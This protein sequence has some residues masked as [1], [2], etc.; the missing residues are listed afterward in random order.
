MQRYRDE[1]QTPEALQRLA[2]LRQRASTG[3]VTLVYAARNEVHN[4]AVVLREIL[5]G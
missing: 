4:N 5:I 1:L 3:M 2:E